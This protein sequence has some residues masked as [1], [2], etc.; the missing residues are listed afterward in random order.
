MKP[1]FV[2]SLWWLTGPSIAVL[3]LAWV[4]WARVGP[5]LSFWAAFAGLSFL[6]GVPLLQLALLQIARLRGR[7]AAVCAVALATATC[8]AAIA[9]VSGAFAAW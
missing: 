8:C 7:Y 9:W 4:G 1:S 6:V 3:L 2:R 5:G